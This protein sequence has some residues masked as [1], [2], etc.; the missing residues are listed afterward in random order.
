MRRETVCRFVSTMHRDT[1][2]HEAFTMR[3]ETVRHCVFTI[4]KSVLYI[5]RCSQ[6]LRHMGVR[7][8][9]LAMRHDSVR[10]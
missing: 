5:I 9:V 1:V 6:L 7:H 4:N 3:F 2:C 10:H 8:S